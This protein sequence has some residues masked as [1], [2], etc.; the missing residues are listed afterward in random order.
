MHG[1]VYGPRELVAGHST[2][3]GASSNPEPWVAQVMRRSGGTVAI[4]VAGAILVA[5]GVAL[6]A[7]ALFHRYEKNLAMERLSHRW[8]TVVKVMGGLGDLARG[9]LLALVGVYLIQAAITSNPA[10]AKSVD[11]ALRALVHHPYGALAIA[12]IGLGLLAFGLYSFFD[13]R[14]RRL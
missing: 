1:S 8:Q 14:L 5:S 3:G 9:S 7:W 10:R 4:E 13:A 6:G 11:Q 2:S 12:L